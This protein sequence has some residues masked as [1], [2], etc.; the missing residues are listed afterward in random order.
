LADLTPREFLLIQNQKSL[1]T[2]GINGTLTRIE[3][4]EQR[5]KGY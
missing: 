5:R 4:L 3:A 2:S 1:L